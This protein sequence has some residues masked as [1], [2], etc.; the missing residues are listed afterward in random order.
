MGL[1]GALGLPSTTHGQTEMACP[2]NAHPGETTCYSG[3]DENGAFYFIARPA[4]WNGTLVVHAHGGPSP[5]G[6]EKLDSAVRPGQNFAVVVREGFAWVS[7]SYRRGGFGVR[8]AAEDSDNARKIF[9]KAFGQPRRTI[10]HGQSYG[11]LVASKLVETYNPD[12]AH[13]YDGALYT[14]GVM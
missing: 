5:F 2:H 10:I 6:E 4:N 13:N 12:G 9:I 8:M 1:A 3:N 14:S 7:S 11:A